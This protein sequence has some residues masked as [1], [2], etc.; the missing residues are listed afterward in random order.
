MALSGLILT[1]GRL[2]EAMHDELK[3]DGKERDSDDPDHNELEVLFD[4]FNVAEEETSAKYAPDP[5]ESAND[6]EG[7]EAGVVH[8][9]D[10]C[11]KGGESS[12]DRN[13]PS[14]DDRLAAVASKE[15]LCLMQVINVE[16]AN[17]FTAEDL[18]ADNLS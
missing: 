12:D 1:Y 6:V 18:G 15:F 14:D 16:P 11:D 8:R 5:D 4:D 7:E 10:A 13:E 2:F 17:V 3:G 9:A